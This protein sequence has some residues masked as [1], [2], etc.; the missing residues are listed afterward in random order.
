M[1]PITIL[2]SALAIAGKALEPV[3]G[4]AVKDGYSAGPACADYAQVCGI[5]PKVG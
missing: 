5:E 3:A 1:D 2:L 4:Q